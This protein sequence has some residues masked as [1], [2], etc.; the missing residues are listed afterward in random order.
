MLQAIKDLFERC[1]TTESTA[2]LNQA[3][4]DQRLQLATAALLIEMMHADFEI[5][6]AEQQAVVAALQEAYQLDASALQGI[7]ELAEQ[8]KHRATELFGFTNLINQHYNDAQKK[9]VLRLLWKVAYADRHFDQHEIHLIRK[10][11]DLLYVPREIAMGL[12]VSVTDK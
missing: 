8:E 6:P 10:I 2:K 1:L 11:A 3:S 5:S 12:R 4:L 7:V 9:E